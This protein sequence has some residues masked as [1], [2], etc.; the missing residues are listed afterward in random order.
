MCMPQFSLVLITL[1]ANDGQTELTWVDGHISRWF[2]GVMIVTHP[3]TNW[4]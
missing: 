3:S 4:A 2:T 1:A